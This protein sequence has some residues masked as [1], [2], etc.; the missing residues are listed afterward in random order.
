MSLRI[1]RLFNPVRVLSAISDNLQFRWD[2]F[3]SNNEKAAEAVVEANTDTDVAQLVDPSGRMKVIPRL[4]ALQVSVLFLAEMLG[5]TY[6]VA[7]LLKHPKTAV[8]TAYRS[9]FDAETWFAGG[10]V[11]ERQIIL[12]YL[13]EAIANCLK[14]QGFKTLDDEGAAEAYVEGLKNLI[15]ELGLT[16]EDGDE[17]LAF[18]L[19]NVMATED[20]GGEAAVFATAAAF[21]ATAIVD[22]GNG[23]EPETTG[24]DS[25]DD[26]P[27]SGDLGD[28]IHEGATET[29]EGN[30]EGT[31]EGEGFL[32]LQEDEGKGA[33]A[34][35]GNDLATQA[36]TSQDAEAPQGGDEG[37]GS[38]AD[39][40]TAPAGE[41]AADA[42]EAAEESRDEDEAEQQ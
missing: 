30:G 4:Q 31:G 28:T 7:T 14:L 25:E 41:D 26:I 40:D 13:Q 2:E 36:D 21:P 15:G 18:F 16:E 9:T 5:L 37:I 23:F 3:K 10:D 24:P 42:V 11:N 29:E 33:P 22:D 35:V 27:G 34:E 20:L 19:P 17:I 39:T 32:G 8:L 6:V 1:N 38:N 12:F